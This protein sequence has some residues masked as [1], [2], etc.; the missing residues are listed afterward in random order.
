MK[1]IIIMIL[2]LFF[3]ISCSKKPENVI[4][5]GDVIIKERELEIKKTKIFEGNLNGVDFERNQFFVN[6]F[7][8]SN[9]EHRLG[10]VDIDKEEIIKTVSLRKGSFQSPTDIFRPS[11]IQRV[12]DKYIIVDNFDKIMLFNN[13]FKL[14][15]SSMFNHLRY[16]IDF[17][18][19]KDQLFFVIGKWNFIRKGR[20]YK[21]ELY[22]F[23]PEKR[24]EFIKKLH[25]G[26]H[27][28]LWYKTEST[29]KSKRTW[30]EG[31]IW[32][33]SSGF[34][35]EGKIYYSRGEE[36]KC[37]VYDLF[38]NRTDVFELTYLKSKKFSVEDN[39][40]LGYYK[41]T[42]W[43]EKSTKTGIKLKYVT[44]P[45]DIYYFGIYDVGENKI[46]V[47]GDL[48]LD[49]MKFRLDIINMD[50]FKYIE[51]IWLPIDWGFKRNICCGARGILQSY[52]NIDKGIHLY[53]GAD[54]D[55]E[56]ITKLTKFIIK[57]DN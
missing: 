42:G 44:Y 9:V 43:Q 22:K 30:Y 14:L 17:Y 18:E 41:T 15:Y 51:S 13:D 35:K 34:E 8:K 19:I 45:D 21:I 28:S 56:M 40:K 23:I 20:R 25:T 26:Y 46:G 37:Y 31:A 11:L 38:N 7:T 24:I 50:S 16:F 2:F 47:V 10:I 1:R 33:S 36:N 4:R 12:D 55:G 57:R 32:P 39:K 53:T 52:I 3:I 49:K 54:E 6:L 27:K 48:D 29:Y 5:I